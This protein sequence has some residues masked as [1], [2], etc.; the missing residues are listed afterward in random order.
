MSV[1]MIVLLAMLLSAPS[2]SMTMAASP[3]HR[4]RGRMSSSG[5]LRNSICPR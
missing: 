1:K 4:A 2:L 5:R 3:E